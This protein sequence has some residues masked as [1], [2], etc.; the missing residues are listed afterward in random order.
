[1]AVHII[2][3]LVSKKDCEDIINCCNDTLVPVSSRPGFY[4]DPNKRLFL[5]EEE[6]LRLNLSNGEENNKALAGAKISSLLYKIKK[7]LQ[8][9]YDVSLPNAEGG[10]AKLTEG[11]FNGLHSD[12]YQIDGSKWEDGS[13]RESEL[14]YSAILYLSDHD[15]DF[16]GGEIIFPQQ[17]LSIKPEAGML[18]FFTGDLDHLHK[19]S[20]VKSGER[21]SVV[22]F[23]GEHV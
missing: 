6:A 20:R 1:M 8:D 11:A 2:K 4:E 16:S 5:P 19:V 3:N 9:F 12:M 10:M 18:V 15:K 7:S 21:Y 23:L 22:A 13:G 17:D 14:N